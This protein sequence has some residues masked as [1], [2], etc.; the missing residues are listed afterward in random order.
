MLPVQP[1]KVGRHLSNMHELAPSKDD[2]L[3][4]GALLEQSFE[5]M[6]EAQRGDM[7]SGTIL[8]IDKQGIII[9]LGL[10]RDGVIPR[11]EVEAMGHDNPFKVGQR[12]TVMVVRPEDHD[13]NLVVS[14]HQA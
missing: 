9:D 5:D 3:D 11:Y 12:V 6:D 10:K 7:L 8:A 1:H 2:S 13:G 4:F 14:V